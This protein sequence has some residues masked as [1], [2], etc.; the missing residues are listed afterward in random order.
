[1][2]L[3]A[4]RRL[5]NLRKPSALRYWLVGITRNKCRQALRRKL[6]APASTSNP[7]S[8]DLSVTCDRPTPLESTLDRENR[9]L[10]RHIMVNVPTTYKQP[11]CLF[12]IEDCTIKQIAKQL[13]L[14]V[15]AVK[16]RLTRGRRY[17]REHALGADIA[18]DRSA[19]A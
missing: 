14:S 17:L 10:L 1:T 5:D 15:D 19:V 2:F 3:E 7:L 4:W 11:L 6:R 12:Y 13:D 9:E 8:D 18:R 16:Q